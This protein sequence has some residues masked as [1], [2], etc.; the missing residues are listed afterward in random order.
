MFKRII[1]WFAG[2]EGSG[3]GVPTVAPAPEQKTGE[4]P[5]LAADQ[6]TEELIAQP[7]VEPRDEANVFPDPADRYDTIFPR[8]GRYQPES[9]RDNDLARIPAKEI[10][11][12]K[13]D[14]FKTAR[15]EQAAAIRSGDAEKVKQLRQEIS[16]LDADRDRVNA[17][18]QAGAEEQLRKIDAGEGRAASQ[19][20]DPKKWAEAKAAES[21]VEKLRQ[22]NPM[23]RRQSAKLSWWERTKRRF[24]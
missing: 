7:M 10:K 2:P 22:A 8:G 5:I 19:L 17:K 18:Y 9:Q 13:S 14:Q 24:S 1:S 4:E 20:R 11:M 23:F 12:S 21:Q 3:G 15:T 16:K 6:T